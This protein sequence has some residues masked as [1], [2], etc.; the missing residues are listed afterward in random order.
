MTVT[1]VRMELYIHVSHIS[2]ETLENWFGTT[3]C[4]RQATIPGPDYDSA[5]SHVGITWSLAFL[6]L[7]SRLARSSTQALA[8]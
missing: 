5:W 6:D 8:V 3:A 7:V 4:N 2:F 1:L